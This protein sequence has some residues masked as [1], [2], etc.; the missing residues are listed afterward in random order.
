M[1]DTKETF[2]YKKEIAILQHRSEQKSSQSLSFGPPGYKPEIAAR[3]KLEK[4]EMS[5]HIPTIV[6]TFTVMFQTN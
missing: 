2:E 6:S 4:P 3:I 1:N 5:Q